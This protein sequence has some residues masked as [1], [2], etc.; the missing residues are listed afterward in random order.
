VEDIR[1]GADSSSSPVRL[2]LSGEGEQGS[3]LEESTA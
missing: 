2:Q 1:S 3:K